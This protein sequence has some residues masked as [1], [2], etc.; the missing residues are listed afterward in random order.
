M[1]TF[2]KYLIAVLSGAVLALALFF[3]IRSCS[4]ESEKE[5]IKIIRDTTYI[6][7]TVRIEKPVAK[8]IRTVD[9]MLVFA[10]DTVRVSDT[11][12]VRL[13]IETKVYS[14][15]T[16]KAQVSGYKPSLDWVEVYPTT[17]VITEQVT[18]QVKQKTHW[19]IG[20]NAGYGVTLNNKQVVLSPYVGVGISYNIFS[21]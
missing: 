4:K 9:T 13:P 19:G 18:K 5:K 14:D 20:I 1:K 12:F 17:V 8:Y 6:H 3:S 15:S 21:W 10:T 7:D 2:M 11:L 16:Y